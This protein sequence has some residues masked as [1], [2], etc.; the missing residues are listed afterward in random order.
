MIDIQAGDVVVCVDVSQ[1]PYSRY[2]CDLKLN[3]VYRVAAV[4]PPVLSAP[5]VLL[6]GARSPHRRG[7]YIAWRF[8]KIQKADEGFATWMHSLRPRERIEARRAE[9]AQTDSVRES[10][11]EGLAQ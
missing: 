8:R 3:G 4:I 9:T 5:G 1:N 7:A 10:R 11:A 6:V 2:A